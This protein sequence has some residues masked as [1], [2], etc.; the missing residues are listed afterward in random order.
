[1]AAP[2]K[3]LLDQRYQFGFFLLDLGT[4]SV[5]VV[6]FKDQHSMFMNESFKNLKKTVIFTKNSS[7]F[8]NFDF[9]HH[10]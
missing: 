1:M 2:E 4:A 3:V 6:D 8:K 5:A 10:M 7:F 9:F